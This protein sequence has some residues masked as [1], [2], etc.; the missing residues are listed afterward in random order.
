MSSK[1]DKIKKLNKKKRAIEKAKGYKRRKDYC[2]ATATEAE[3]NAK[4]KCEY[5]SGTCVLKDNVN[6]RNEIITNLE[7][8]GID[9][10]A[11]RAGT[12]LNRI[13]DEELRKVNKE[14]DDLDAY[15]DVLSKTEKIIN[16]L[17]SV[18]IRN[19]LGKQAFPNVVTPG[20]L[21]L[22]YRQALV[23]HLLQKSKYNMR[24]L[25]QNFL[26]NND[27]LLFAIKPRLELVKYLIGN[28][29]KLRNVKTQLG[30]S[31][32]IKNVHEL[33][34]A[35]KETEPLLRRYMHFYSSKAPMRL[36]GGKKNYPSLMERV[37]FM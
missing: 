26:S 17:S 19:V 29:E 37:P 4:S 12:P 20:E 8:V 25:Y 30:K 16:D 24:N 22:K 1:A 31:Q 10:A 23:N 28:I 36:I 33:D 5:T 32:F 9:L 11:L 34:Y 15:K 13:L 14:L 7:D 21:G 6:I 18:G 27:L 35:L 2:S 3:C